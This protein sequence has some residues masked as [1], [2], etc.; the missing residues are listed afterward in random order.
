MTELTDVF[1]V[2]HAAGL[3][4]RHI[5]VGLQRQVGNTPTAM[6]VNDRLQL[7]RIDV[8][9]EW[10][11]IF[12]IMRFIDDDIDEMTARQLLV[13]LGRG[14]IHVT[15]HHV[16]GSN[17]NLT[18]EMLGPASL[19]GRND[20]L[21][22]EVF[23]YGVFQ[24]IIIDRTGIRLVPQHQPRPLAIAHGTRAG[25]GE[26]IDIDVGTP[27]EEGIEPCLGDRRLTLGPCGH[28]QRF[29][30]LDFKRLGTRLMI[31]RT[32]TFQYIN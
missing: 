32:N 12:R 15:R 9:L 31:H 10:M 16:T 8:A 28:A 26:E 11:V 3:A 5:D 22:S 19:M 25:I 29:H 23:A 21:V 24:M 7:F 18:Q 27:Q 14:E 13:E 20:M 17:A 2:G 30:H 4:A 1:D 6:L